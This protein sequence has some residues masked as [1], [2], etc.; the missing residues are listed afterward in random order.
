MP[1]PSSSLATLRPDLAS[2]LEEFDLAMDSQ[3]FV[4]QQ[5]LPVMDVAKASGK[6]GIIPIEQLLQYRDTARAPGSGYNR[7]SFK[8]ESGSYATAEHGAEEPID[9]NE[10]TMYA[11]YFNAEV[12]STARAYRAVMENQERRVAAA[13]F[14]ATTWSG[15][16]LA[17]SI[18]H[19]W[20]DY[21]N[22]VPINDVE[23]AVRKVYEGS[24]LWPNALIVSRLVFRNLRLCSQVLDRLAASGAGD[25]IRATDVTAAQ[26][27]ALFDLDRIIIAGGTKN[28]GGLGDAATLAPIWSGEYAMVAKVATTND[29]REP[30]VGRIFHWAEDGSQIDGRVES[31][32]DET[33]RGDVVRVRHQVEEKILYPQAGHLLSNIT[34]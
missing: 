16:A 24:G 32:R 26:L 29:M 18:T 13:V 3:G 25:K 34:T 11:D 19:E 10:A 20:D 2:S 17:T 22:A 4:G 28:T 7:G 27:A 15:A 12:I 21:T 33:I 8:F 30:C 6:F 1:S 5:V 9:D 31:Y 14:N 23:G